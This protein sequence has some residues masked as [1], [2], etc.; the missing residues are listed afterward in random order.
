MWPKR[1][2][3]GG[4]PETTVSADLVGWIGQSL[5]IVI[6]HVELERASVRCVHVLPAVVFSRV[7]VVPRSHHYRALHNRPKGTGLYR[8]KGGRG[9]R[10][11]SPG[12]ERHITESL[13]TR[14]RGS[15][16][17]PRRPRVPG[18]RS[19]SLPSPPARRRR[20]KSRGGG[21]SAAVAGPS[22][23]R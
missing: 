3:T 2:G 22:P 11:Y 15:R 16:R 10:K 9:V 17:G 13:A 21:R 12:A 23:R 8:P 1:R 18:R 19:R 5:A 7:H 6:G 14:T 4:V 20:G